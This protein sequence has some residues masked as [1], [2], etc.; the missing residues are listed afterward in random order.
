MC[1][2]PCGNYRSHALT[3]SA[4]FGK[5]FNGGDTI[6]EMH[7]KMPRQSSAASELIE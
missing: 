5:M 2:R 3:A 6:V 7:S 4:I 1:L